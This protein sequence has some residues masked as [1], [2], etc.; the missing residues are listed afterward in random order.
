MPLFFLFDL[1]LEARAE[2]L[3]IISWVSWEKRSFH[4]DIIKLTDL[5]LLYQKVSNGSTYFR[6]LQIDDC[7]GQF[8]CFLDFSLRNQQLKLEAG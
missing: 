6:H 4:K 7:F 3:E 1:S 8:Q 5:S 2:I